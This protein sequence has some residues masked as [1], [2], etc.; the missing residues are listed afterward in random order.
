MTLQA[1]Q[2]VDEVRAKAPR[3]RVALYHGAHRSRDFP[4]SLLACYDV[5]VSTYNVLVSECPRE[6]QG[7]MMVGIF[8][9]RWHRCVREGFSPLPHA[10]FIQPKICS[11]ERDRRA[12]GIHGVALLNVSCHTACMA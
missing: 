6:E 10:N 2:W 9:V 4:P 3:L 12:P 5:V 8:R 11:H 7:G 1:Q